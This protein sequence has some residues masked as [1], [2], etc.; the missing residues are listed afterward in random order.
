MALLEKWDHD[1]RGEAQGE[2]VEVRCTTVTSWADLSDGEMDLRLVDFVGGGV[3]GASGDASEDI[4]NRVS[5]PLW[6]WSET[7]TTL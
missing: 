3:K 6:N 5:G 2:S 7:F 1:L 4:G